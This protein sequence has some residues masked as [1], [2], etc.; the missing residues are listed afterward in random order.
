LFFD[1]L[2]VL[3][4]MFKEEWM[5]VT[6]KMVDAVCDPIVDLAVR[7]LSRP[8]TIT[9]EELMKTLLLAIETIQTITRHVPEEKS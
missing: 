6:R 4:R 3:P 9:K 2:Y 5:S 1:Q 7:Q 8:E